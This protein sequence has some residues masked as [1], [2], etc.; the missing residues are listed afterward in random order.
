MTGLF[1]QI[2]SELHKHQDT[3][4]CLNILSYWKSGFE[5][6]SGRALLG[7][8][9]GH[10]LDLQR[11]LPATG[12]LFFESP[13]GGLKAVSGDSATF[14]EEV[15]DTFVRFAS[16]WQPRNASDSASE[17]LIDNNGMC[18]VIDFAS[19]KPIRSAD[20]SISF[21]IGVS[22]KSPVP[23]SIVQKYRITSHGQLLDRET[24]L[25]VLA[26][27]IDRWSPSEIRVTTD[28]ISELLHDVNRVRRGE[29]V[30]G[31]ITYLRGVEEIT[32]AQGDIEPFKDGILVN[33]SSTHPWWKADA[34]SLL[35]LRDEMT[36]K[37]LR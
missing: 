22:P 21:V 16:P 9:H 1:P 5:P 10:L 6:K 31:L 36:N 28:E 12:L 18:F 23:N 27:T 19:S 35:A 8:I 17:L 20:S 37:V 15:A 7:D 4:A 29:V 32:L 24:V 30:P 25:K 34:K 13:Q 14:E 2:P 3:P 26:C 11:V 33:S